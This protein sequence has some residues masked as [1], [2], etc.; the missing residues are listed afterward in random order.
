[1]ISAFLTQFIDE[2]MRIKGS[3]IIPK[4]LIRYEYCNHW[5]WIVESLGNTIESQFSKDSGSEESIIK[6][7]KAFE[8]IAD[9]I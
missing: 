1:M 4:L 9:G 6:G 8:K 7:H 5:F 2:K 3:D